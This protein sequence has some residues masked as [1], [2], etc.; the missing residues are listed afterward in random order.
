MDHNLTCGFGPHAFRH[1][2]ARHT[3]KICTSVAEIVATSQN[4]GHTHVLTTLRSYGQI[5]RERQ[6]SL[7]PASQ[8][9][10]YWRT[11]ADAAK[12]SRCVGTVIITHFSG[13]HASNQN[14]LFRKIWWWIRTN[15]PY[16]FRHQPALPL[17]R[18]TNLMLALQNQSGVAARGL[19]FVILTASRSG[20]G[21]RYYMGKG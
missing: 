14:Q 1:M 15:K 6:V 9:I 18:V 7:S 4:L 11:D 8:A 2:L 19:S 3:A 21:E 17:S 16:A 13:V 20:E 10:R 5:S 12:A